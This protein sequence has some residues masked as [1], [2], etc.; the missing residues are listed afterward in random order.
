[1]RVE[2]RPGFH[3]GRRYT[4]NQALCL[5][6]AL[7]FGNVTL[8]GGESGSGKTSLIDAVIAVLTGNERRFAKYNAA[9]S[10]SHSSKKSRRD[11]ASYILGADDSGVPHR[12]HGAHGYAAIY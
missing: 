12:P 7:R 3:P 2:D 10:E 1:M 4:Q 11:L 9:Q 8:L 5:S 6:V